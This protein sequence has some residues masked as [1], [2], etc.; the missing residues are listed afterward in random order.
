MSL[1]DLSG[2]NDLSAGG[3]EHGFRV[4]APEGPERSQSFDSSQIQISEIDAG[5]HIDSWNEISRLDLF[6]GGCFKSPGKL[7][8]AG[9]IEA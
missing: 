7:S 2:I 8:Y 5:I 6:P 1:A 9:D 3:A 4:A